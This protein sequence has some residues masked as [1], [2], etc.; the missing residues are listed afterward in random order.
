MFQELRT[1]L[2]YVYTAD[3]NFHVDLDGA[4]FSVSFASDP[5]NVSRA[6]AAVAAMIRRLQTHPLAE[7]ELQRAKALL[8]AQR[9]LPLD[10]YDG[11]AAD[12][13]SGAEEGYADGS[14]A[15]FWKALL[16][17]TPAQV[18]HALR[19]VDPARF[20]QVIVEPGR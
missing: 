7:T 19:R 4:E 16:R 20:T 9:V 14:E 13:I 12:M 8:V 5:K 2:G 18:A 11:L 6:N 1:R 10:S 17:T 3:S 15:W